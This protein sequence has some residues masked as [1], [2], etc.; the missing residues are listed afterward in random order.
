MGDETVFAVG[1]V[2]PVVGKPGSEV[3][4]EQEGREPGGGQ[5]LLLAA[6]Q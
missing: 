1:G 2:F 6:L 4:Q 3:F 5:T